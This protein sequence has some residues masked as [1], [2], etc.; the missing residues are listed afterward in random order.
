MAKCHEKLRNT[1]NDFQHKISKTIID[2]NQAVMVETLKIKNMIKNRKLAKHIADASWGNL[3]EKLE[4]KAKQAS[5]PFIKI[6]QWF[7]SSKTCHVCHHRMEEMPL[8][9]RRWDCPS[10]KTTSIDRDINAEI[11]IKHQG[12][13]ILKVAGLSVSA[14]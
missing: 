5:K 13:T 10:C 12:I 14:N 7:A 1:R 3:I 11:N 9:V 8:K 4:Y 2:E 6:D